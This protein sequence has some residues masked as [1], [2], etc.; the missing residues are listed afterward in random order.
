MD[1]E[2]S[3]FYKSVIIFVAIFTLGIGGIAM[4]LQLRTWP[5]HI[6]SKGITL[7]NGRYLSWEEFT[8]KKDVAVVNQRGNQIASRVEL[9]FGKTVVRIVVPSLK[10]GNAIVQFVDDIVLELEIKG[11]VGV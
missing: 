6:D 3:G 2:L 8:N 1:V 10:N 4:W 7:R 9:Y 11:A 5:K